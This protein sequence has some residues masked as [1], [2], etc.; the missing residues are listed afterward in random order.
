MLTRKLIATSAWP[1]VISNSS[2]CIGSK[3]M[4]VDA[5]R[6]MVYTTASIAG[7]SVH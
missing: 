7:S 2:S 4:F 5:P 3:G 6:L 1:N